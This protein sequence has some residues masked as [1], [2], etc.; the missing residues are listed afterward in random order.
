M[1]IS[2]CA[3]ADD[4]AGLPAAQLQSIKWAAYQASIHRPGTCIAPMACNEA[5]QEAVQTT[6]RYVKS[7]FPTCMHVIRGI[8]SLRQQTSLYTRTLHPSRTQVV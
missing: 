4:T 1:S 8:H 5:K 2:P 7:A 6:P 3:A